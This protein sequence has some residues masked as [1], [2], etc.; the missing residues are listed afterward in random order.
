M[1]FY[2]LLGMILLT[3]CSNSLEHAHWRN[4][5]DI[6]ELRFLNEIDTPIPATVTV[7]N[8]KIEFSPQT[9]VGIPIENTFVKKI[10]AKDG[11]LLSV[12]SSYQKDLQKFQKLESS[13]FIVTE[14]IKKDLLKK[15]S[16]INKN[17]LQTLS[18]L[19]ESSGRMVWSFS[20]FDVNGIPY[21]I[22][23]DKNFKVLSKL[24]VGFNLFDGAAVIFPLGPKLSQLKE[25]PVKN[26]SFNPPLSNPQFTITSAL[27]GTYNES[28][29]I[30]QFSPQDPRFDQVQVYYYV[31]QTLNWIRSSLG[32]EMNLPLDIQLHVGFPEKTNAAFYYQGK[33]RLG[34]GDDLVYS[35]IPQDPSIV[36]H[37]IFHALIETLSRLPFQG[38]GG[39]LNEAFA[40]FFTSQMLGRPGLGESSYLQAPYKRSV[41]NEKKWSDRT[42]ALYGDS[43]IVSG[44]LWEL[45]QNIS[46]IKVRNVALKTLIHLNPASQLID[47]N[48]ECR[49][50]L[51]EYLT[52]DELTKA[53]TILGRREFPK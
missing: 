2:L 13:S 14:K 34:A 37:E 30:L 29:R 20:Y 38:E 39:S 36:S 23:M 24:S 22:K 8:E 16:F 21:Q 32:V 46:S 15:F 17:D 31:S 40:D 49:E 7:L 11:E 41:A 28:D 5:D 42:G 52:E 48:R 9:F 1:N 25:V 10:N 19:F 6:R 26:L 12:A 35:K 27:A 53:Q 43:L 18:P 51:H 47:F 50:A 4:G 33:I 44:L 3:A 45:S